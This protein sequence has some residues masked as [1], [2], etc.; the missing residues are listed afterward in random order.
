MRCRG[1]RDEGVDDGGA[2]AGWGAEGGRGEVL[3]FFVVV[4]VRLG[5]DG[6]TFLVASTRLRA[7]SRLRFT[8]AQSVRNPHPCR[9]R[10]GRPEG[11][12]VARCSRLRHFDRTGLES[13]QGKN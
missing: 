11:K 6:A 12:V 13:I 3:R 1:G 2:P 10:Q 9:C 4:G 7:L 8:L 5:I